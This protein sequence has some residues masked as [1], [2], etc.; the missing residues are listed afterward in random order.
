M[1][2]DFRIASTDAKLGIPENKINIC[3]FFGGLVADHLPPAIALELLLTGNPLD[4][5][6]AYEL[7]FLNRLVEKDEVENEAY[8]FA[9]SICQNAPVSV[10]R[11]K[12]LFYKSWE[13]NKSQ[14]LDRAY[15]ISEQLRKME[16]CK[17][18]VQAFKEKRK[19]Q[20][21]ER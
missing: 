2:C 12:D 14:S 20:W 18:G 13:M 1:E 17:E 10:R 8:K 7:G 21:K 11:T 4:A 9:E 16:D 6:R 3:P 5:K 15:I 19:P